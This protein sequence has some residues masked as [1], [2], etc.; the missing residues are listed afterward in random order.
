MTVT[1]EAD[2]IGVLQDN[3]WRVLWQWDRCWDC[4]VVLESDL[5]VRGGEQ[6]AELHT[7]LLVAGLENPLHL[8]R[9]KETQ[10]ERRVDRERLGKATQGYSH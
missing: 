10:R 6:S 5:N 9:A 2:G 7:F 8:Q 3:G 4:A 1:S